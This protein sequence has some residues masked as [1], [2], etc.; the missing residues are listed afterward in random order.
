MTR[1][2][3]ILHP[4]QYIQLRQA[5][6]GQTQLGH[7]PKAGAGVRKRSWYQFKCL[8]IGGRERRC[9]VQLLQGVKVDFRHTPEKGDR[10]R[11][12]GQSRGWYSW[13]NTPEGRSI[14]TLRLSNCS[15]C[16]LF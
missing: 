6:A 3:S 1:K 13:H 8:K 16:A 12:V 10:E 5:C 15:S 7:R 2:H 11:F 9:I 14:K 4:A